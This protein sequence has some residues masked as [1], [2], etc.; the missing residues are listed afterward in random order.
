M[1]CDYLEPQ[2]I[3]VHD[4]DDEVQESVQSHL[5]ETAPTEHGMNYNL[6]CHTF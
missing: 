2:N 4:K 5:H 3:E 6:F 1:F